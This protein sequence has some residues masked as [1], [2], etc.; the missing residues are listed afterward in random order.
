MRKKIEGPRK[1]FFRHD[2]IYR[3]DG[4]L[5]LVNQGRGPAFRSGPGQAIGRAGCHTPCPSFAMSS[6]RLFLEGSVA[7]VAP[8]R[9]ADHPTIKSSRN[10]ANRFSSNGNQCLN[11]LSQPKGPLQLSSFVPFL[12]LKSCSS[13][14]VNEEPE[15]RRRGGFSLTAGSRRGGLDP[16]TPQQQEMVQGC[17]PVGSRAPALRNVA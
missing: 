5:P 17:A 12:D 6:G 9:F 7:T 14:F 13:S 2:G 3:S 4:S 1:A 11:R 15:R 10:Q 8:L 16:V